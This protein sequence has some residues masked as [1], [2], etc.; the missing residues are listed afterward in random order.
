M[1]KRIV[2][3][4]SATCYVLANAIGNAMDNN[5]ATRVSR[6]RDGACS[7]TSWY[8]VAIYASSFGVIFE[9]GK[10]DE[11]LGGVHCD[12]CIGKPV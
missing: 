10:Q 4:R 6:F 5:P 12:G 11:S 9:A 1:S 8:P 7:Q 3:D 2:R